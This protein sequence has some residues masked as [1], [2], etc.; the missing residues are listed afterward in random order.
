FLNG[1][2]LGERTLEPKKV[3]H[4][5]WSVPYE[6]GE[7]KVVAKKDGT[8]VTTDVVHTAGEPAKIE[9]TA[10]RSSIAADGNDLSFVT[11]KI[12]DKN[13]N[14]CPNA[15]QNMTY[16]IEGPGSIAGLDDGDATNHQRFQGTEHH[17]FHGMGLA[18]IRGSTTAGAI[19]LKVST[20]GLPDAQI[21]I[22]TQSKRF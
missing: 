5:A 12:L 1:K 21:E 4:V 6:P 3:L 7:L 10:D 13:G 14:L 20:P 11:V 22:T 15:S 19:H 17:V 16:A 8:V 2:S 18:I 9:L